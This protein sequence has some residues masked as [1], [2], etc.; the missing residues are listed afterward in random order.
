MSPKRI[1][2]RKLARGK[3]CQ[4]RLVGVC[5]RDP[6]TTVLA[7]VRLAG[8]TGVGLKANDFLGAW[9]CSDCHRVTE[10]YKKDNFIQRSFLEGVI[11]TQ[12]Q[13]LKVCNLQKM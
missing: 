10:R 8:I 13:V 12:N 3:E 2:L 1:D 4:I 7:H 6:A 5:N 11:R 9:A